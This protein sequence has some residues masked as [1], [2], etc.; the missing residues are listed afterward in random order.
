MPFPPGPNGY[1]RGFYNV[2]AP[3]WCR[4][5]DQFLTYEY[6]GSPSSN[7]GKVKLTCANCAATTGDIAVAT[8]I[9]DTVDMWLE[10][11]R[12]AAHDALMKIEAV[13][14]VSEVEA[15]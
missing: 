8:Q 13:G 10:R 9:Y 14:Q 11:A 4:H 2:T 6:T 12:Q 1:P 5:K 7:T 3:K 15:P